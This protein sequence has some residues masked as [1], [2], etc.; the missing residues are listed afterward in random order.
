VAAVPFGTWE[1][2][3]QGKGGIAILPVGAMCV[4]AMQAAESLAAEGLDVTVVNCRFLKPVDRAALDA[5]MRDHRVLL[6]V[7]D[8]VVTNGFGAY[9]AGIVQA[10]SPR[11]RVVALGAPDKTYE[12]APRAKQLESVGLSAAGI[13]ARVRS[14]HAEAAAPPS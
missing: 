1:V 2:L 11:V 3:R 13:A 4:P 6:T 8:G 5:L 14:L 7:E 10:I 9:L 12:H